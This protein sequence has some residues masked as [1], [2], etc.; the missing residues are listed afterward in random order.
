MT[1]KSKNKTTTPQPNNNKGLYEQKNAERNFK[2]SKRRS[3]EDFIGKPT[4]PSPL[5][6]N[7]RD[8]TSQKYFL[9]TLGL[10]PSHQNK[11]KSRGRAGSM[12]Y[13][14]PRAQFFRIFI[15]G[16]TSKKIYELH[17]K[18]FNIDIWKDLPVNDSTSACL[19]RNKRRTEQLGVAVDW[20]N[21]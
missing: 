6:E 9:Q 19:C 20:T 2:E 16:T 12:A 7:T 13:T 14:F 1:C 10:G 17:K 4:I 3:L 21:L 8:Y 18:P 15:C 5:I 11:D